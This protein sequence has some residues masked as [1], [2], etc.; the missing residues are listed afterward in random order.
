MGDTL[1]RLGYLFLTFIYVEAYPTQQSWAQTA[2]QWLTNFIY[3]EQPVEKERR[4]RSLAATMYLHRAT[5]LMLTVALCGLIYGGAFWLYQENLTNLKTYENFFLTY[6]VAY[7]YN[8]YTGKPTLTAVENALLHPQINTTPAAG[9]ATSIPVLMYHR[10]TTGNDPYN[11]TPAAFKAQMF[12]LKRAG[13]TTVSAED[14]ASFIE[15]TKKLPPKSVLI[16][17]DDGTKDSYY[18]TEPIL[19]ALHFRAT[20]FVITK[21]SIENSAGSHYYLSAIELRAMERSGNWDLEVHTRDGHSYYPINANGVQGQFYPN[22]L[23]LPTKHRMETDAEYAS[24][25]YDDIYTAKQELENFTHK[26]A[27]VFAFPFADI[28]ENNTSNYPA[29]P[30]IL[31]KDAQR[32]FKVAMML[33]Y[34]GRARSQGYYNSKQLYSY[35]VQVLFGKWA[36]GQGLVDFLQNGE[37][38][39]LPYTDNFTSNHGWQAAWGT[40]SVN[41]GA[42]TISS[43]KGSTGAGVLLDG[44][45]GWGNYQFS[46]QATL[47]AGKS[48]GFIARMQG[49]AYRIGCY[50]GDNHVSITRNQGSTATTLKEDSF[51]LP[52]TNH[53]QTLGVIVK[54][55]EIQCLD[56]GTVVLQ[57][58]D[59]AMPATGSIGFSTWDPTKQPIL[60]IQNIKVTPL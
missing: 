57:T 8:R 45:N 48:Y 29:A 11:V 54:G 25:V 56:N 30:T 10:I 27:N 47:A 59:Q 33:Y 50:F 55:D 9:Y 5:Y 13:Y 60:N 19:K 28:G 21:Y 43:N 6:K 34:P 22:K 52:I 15:G 23:W 39:T 20:E 2:W 38:K 32:L 46:A 14:Y 41:H 31:T 26:P 12:A 4:S 7:D 44:T 37:A 3:I 49:D 24:R 17:F 16:T 53:T 35:R 42:L 58:I 51:T 18:P 1:K 40:T 36:N